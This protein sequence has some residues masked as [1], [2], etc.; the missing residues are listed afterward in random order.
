MSDNPP[1]PH[2]RARHTFTRPEDGSGVEVIRCGLISDVVGW[3]AAAASGACVECKR[4]RHPC[5]LN[6]PAIKQRLR[7]LLLTRIEHH[8]DRHEDDHPLRARYRDG[9]D[10]LFA[11]ARQHAPEADISEALVSAVRRGKL[12]AGKAQQ[13]AQKHLP[14]FCQ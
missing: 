10:A 5:T 11:L 4:S 6:S 2:E 8:L 7:T 12:S 9:V 14:E 13:L 3:N 1:C